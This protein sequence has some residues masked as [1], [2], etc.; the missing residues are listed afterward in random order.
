MMRCVIVD[1]EPLAI[2]ILETYLG[3][4]KETT[5]VA[6][7][8]DAIEAFTYLQQNRVDL[9]FLDLDMPML[10]G[11]EL[12]KN[13]KTKPA[14][15][16]TTAYREYAVEGFELDVTDYLVKPIA[17]P[18]FLKAVNKVSQTNPVNH[19]PAVQPDKTEGQHTLWL[20]VDKKQV[21]VMVKDILY[22]QSL[23]D[24]V[25]VVMPSQKLVTY[26]TLQAILD[27]LSL[28]DFV[29][30]HK[31]YIVQVSK[32]NCIEGNMV[33]VNGETLPVGRSYR[34]NLL[35]LTNK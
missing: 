14:V 16:I 25:R 30:I 29:Q 18:R 34:N 6:R 3:Q 23:K 22:I 19:E 2:E 17:F 7:F 27:R 13:L 20:K 9:V 26:H 10:N 12:L 24:Y 28:Y 15:I 1:D 5:V 31:S 35:G 21:P 33:H 32:I 11:M 8:T 4:M